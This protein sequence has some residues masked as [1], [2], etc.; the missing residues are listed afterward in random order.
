MRYKDYELPI[1]E[2]IYPDLQL[3]GVRHSDISERK[4]RKS[5]EQFKKTLTSLDHLAFEGNEMSHMINLQ[6]RKLSYEQ[7]ALRHFDSQKHFLDEESDYLEIL[8]KYE[9]SPYLFGIFKA[10]SGFVSVIPNS[11]PD[12]FF[13]NIRAYLEF[14]KEIYP[15]YN[16]VDIDGI[17]RVFPKLM[18]EFLAGD[19]LFEACLKGANQFNSYLARVRDHM[20]YAPGIVNLRSDFHGQKGVI[21]G[22]SHIIYLR[23]L[24]LGRIEPDYI[25]W[26]QYT[27]KLDTEQK[28]GI[29]FLEDFVKRHLNA[30]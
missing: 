8:G 1:Y 4:H 2:Q 15:G 14:G 21:L 5:I 29:R 7:L 19:T 23:D 17:M 3:I 10:V 18:I 16:R 25:G 6:L 11:K 20:V 9:V 13:L 28:R 24:L 12:E 27:A 30:V 22:E 26:R